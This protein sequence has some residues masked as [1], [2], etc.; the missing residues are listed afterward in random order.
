M[1]TTANLHGKPAFSKLDL[2]RSYHQIPVSQDSIPKTAI[3]TSFGLYEVLVTLFG[4]RNA[5]QTFQRMMDCILHDLHFALAYIDDGLVASKSPDEHRDHLRYVCKL[6]AE[7]ELVLNTEKSIL[8]VPSVSFLSHVVDANGIAP[9]Q[10][11]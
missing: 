10:L 1:E 3:I 8:G 6:P 9:F 2:V 4:L 7:N 11:M 5:D